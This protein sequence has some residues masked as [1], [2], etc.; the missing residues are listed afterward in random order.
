MERF[1]L[2]LWTRS[3]YINNQC[4][5]N[6]VLS[7]LAELQLSFIILSLYSGGY[8]GVLSLLCRLR[9]TDDKIISPIL[10]RGSMIPSSVIS[11]VSVTV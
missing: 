9:L 5:V 11:V 8:S 1:V 6:G 10:P 2:N 7:R 4:G 3:Y